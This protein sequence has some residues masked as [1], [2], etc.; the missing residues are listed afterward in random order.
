MGDGWFELLKNL[1][2]EIKRLD[3]KYKHK[4]LVVQLKEKFGGLR[5]YI[6]GAPKKIHK[7]IEKAEKESL[8]TCESCGTK[9]NVGYTTGWITTLCGKCADESKPDVELSTYWVKN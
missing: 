6:E 5:F 4:T 8:N 2:I 9:E 1:I 3:K 7:A